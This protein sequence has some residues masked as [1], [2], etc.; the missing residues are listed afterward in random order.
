MV[1]V[2]KIDEM[3]VQILPQELDGVEYYEVVTKDTDIGYHYQESYS[4][5]LGKVKYYITDL[6]DTFVLPGYPEYGEDGKI[7]RYW[8]NENKYYQDSSWVPETPVVPEPSGDIEPSGDTEPPQEPEQPVNPPE[9][10]EDITDKEMED[11]KDQYEEETGESAGG[12][13][14]FLQFLKWLFALFGWEW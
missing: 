4:A 10:I 9:N 12:A 8:V 6:G 3:E 2:G 13:W 7:L 14:G 1:P 5:E 11:L